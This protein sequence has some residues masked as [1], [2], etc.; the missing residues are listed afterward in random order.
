M[1]SSALSAPVAWGWLLGLALALAPAA[2]ATPVERPTTAK[3]PPKPPKRLRPP[4]PITPPPPK[5][6]GAVNVITLDRDAPMLMSGPRAAAPELEGPPPGPPGPPAPEDMVSFPEGSFVMG[7]TGKLPQCNDDREP[8]RTITLAAFAI[9]RRVATQA[10]YKACMAAGVCAEPVEWAFFEPEE[11][12]QEPVVGMTW[13]QAQLFCRWRGRRL[14]SEAEWA[15]AARGTEGR[16]FPWG[17]TLRRARGGATPEGVV[18]MLGTV[19]QWTAD[20][21][22]PDGFARL[23]DRDPTG[24]PSGTEKVLRGLER[25]FSDSAYATFRATRHPERTDTGIGVRCALTLG[26]RQPTPSV[27]PPPAA[28]GAPWTVV[29]VAVGEAHTCALDAEGGVWCWGDDTF[30]QLAP[31]PGR[32]PK[33]AAQRPRR[34][35]LPPQEAVEAGPL[36]TCAQGPNGWTRCWGELNALVA[37]DRFAVGSRLCGVL[38][39]PSGP[40]P[41]NPLDFEKRSPQPVRGGGPLTGALACTGDASAF[42]D[43]GDPVALTGPEGPLAVAEPR[44]AIALAVGHRHACAVDGTGQPWCWGANA[45]GQLGVDGDAARALPVKAGEAEHPLIRLMG[46]SDDFER[47]PP[48]MGR[49]G[50]VSAISV[51]S[52]HSC[53]L[54][55]SGQVSCWGRGTYGALGVPAHPRPRDRALGPLEMPFALP[56]VGVSDAVA[57]VDGQDHTCAIRP[58]GQL[59]CWGDNQ[60]G[61][62]GDGTL[63]SRARA[64]PVRGLPGRVVRADG[65]RQH[66]CAVIEDGSLWCWGENRR[67][68]LG[69]GTRMARRRPVRVT[70]P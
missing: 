20:W 47:P 36:S 6:S 62:L 65:G 46:P 13:A 56:V 30:R 33:I 16:M 23:A 57:L 52:H 29:D 15:R 64:A 3:P 41:M 39:D 63:D 67:G 22:A 21:Y 68:Q 12:P 31:S 61:Q 8:V 1:R 59:W 60:G 14:P 2:R 37:F 51:G 17:T 49:H 44:G 48:L 5:P 19:K 43:G 34:V 24:D 18:G 32:R 69:D 27:R 4:P 50:P 70:P 66:T 58:D 55:R 25:M 26:D 7:C 42:N 9:D 28:P 45:T 10:Q 54:H 53:A 38:A 35:P 40:P 11:T